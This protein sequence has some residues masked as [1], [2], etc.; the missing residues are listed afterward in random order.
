MRKNLHYKIKNKSATRSRLFIATRKGQGY[1]TDKS[2]DSRH[3]MYGKRGIAMEKL[4]QWEIFKRVFDT[5]CL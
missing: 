3:M 1:N 5:F 4:S 2:A